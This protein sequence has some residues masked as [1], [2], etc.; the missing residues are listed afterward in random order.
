[1][2]KIKWDIRREGHKWNGEESF[3][4][5]N[6]TPEKLEMHRG[7]LYWSDEERITMLALLLENVGIDEA[8]KLGDIKIWQEAISDQQSD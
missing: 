3:Q 6:L 2:E 7:K 1:M 5:F 4:K 8:L